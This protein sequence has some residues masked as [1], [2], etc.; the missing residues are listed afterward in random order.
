MKQLGELIIRGFLK[1]LSEIHKQELNRFDFCTFDH[2]LKILTILKAEYPI[3]FELLGDIPL[4][5]DIF[6]EFPQLV[7]KYDFPSVSKNGTFND[8]FFTFIVGFGFGVYNTYIIDTN[9]EKKFKLGFVTKNGKTYRKE[10]FYI[11]K[12]I[13]YIIQNLKSMQDLNLQKKFSSGLIVWNYSNFLLNLLER[14]KVSEG[15]DELYEN[16]LL[17][18]FEVLCGFIKKANKENSIILQTLEIDGKISVIYKEHIRMIFRRRA[19][20][21]KL[22]TKKMKAEATKFYFQKHLNDLFEFPEKFTEKAF[23]E[24]KHQ[25]TVNLGFS[26]EKMAEPPTEINGKFI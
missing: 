10:E 12:T 4:S 16:V 23:P 5:I 13:L 19:K 3:I 2:L 25:K 11:Y 6:S 22:E 14:L 7:K 24:Q 8:Y 18:A 21:L 15:M 20:R 17:E 9:I 1:E 26:A